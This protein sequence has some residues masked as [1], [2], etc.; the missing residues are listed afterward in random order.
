ME[1]QS[2]VVEEKQIIVF[3]EK[4]KLRNNVKKQVFHS[5]GT[6]AIILDLHG[7]IVHNGPIVRLDPST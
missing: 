1:E 7:L 5:T 4:R 2:P 3:L 6:K